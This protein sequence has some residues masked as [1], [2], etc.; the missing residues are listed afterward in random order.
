MRYS[1]IPPPLL[2]PRSGAVRPGQRPPVRSHAARKRLGPELVEQL[3]RDYD[4]GESTAALCASYGLGKGTV[5]GLLAEWGAKMRGQ[6]L[7]DDQL[8]EA[9]RL[10]LEQGLPIRKIGPRLGC[11]PDAVRLALLRSG[12]TLRKPWE[13]GP[14]Q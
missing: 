2:F 1:K 7:P 13:R 10:Y 11:S 14:H 5:L 9:K 3:V 12:V 4:A 6:G 8:P